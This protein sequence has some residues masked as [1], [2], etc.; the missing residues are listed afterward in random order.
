MQ[1]RGYGETGASRDGGKPRLYIQECATWRD[2]ACPHLSM[3]PSPVI[4]LVSYLLFY[5]LYGWRRCGCRLAADATETGVG[6]VH[7]SARPHT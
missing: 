2:G 7:M 3:P 5:A 4:Q 6:P 1:R